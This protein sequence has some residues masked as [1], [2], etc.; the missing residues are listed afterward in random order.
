MKAKK[1]IFIALAVLRSSWRCFRFTCTWI[2]AK[3]KS[4]RFTV[5]VTAVAFGGFYG[6]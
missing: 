6:F 5:I 4:I 3:C 1:I 2:S